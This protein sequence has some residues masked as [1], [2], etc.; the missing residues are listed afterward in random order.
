MEES[1]GTS[2][3]PIPERYRHPRMSGQPPAE[4]EIR[5][6]ARIL[7]QMSEAVFLVDAR[8]RTIVYTKPGSERMFGYGQGEL[9]GK[10]MTTLAL[11][12]VEAPDGI[13]AA[14]NA[15][16]YRKGVWKGELLNLKKNGATFWCS[17]AVSTFTHS[18]YGEVWLAVFQDISGR[19][20]AEQALHESE[21]FL[22]S[23]VENIPDMIFVK[24][25]EELRFIKFNGAGEELLGYRREEL[26]GKNDY[27]FFPPEEAEFF[28]RKDREVL[29]SKQL[30]D[31]AEEFIDTR[32]HGKRVLHTKKIP[33]ADGQGNPLFLLGISEDVTERNRLDRERERYLRFFRLSS[34]AMCIADPFGCFKDVNPALVR[35]TGYA[36]EELIAIPFLDFVH[37]EDREDTTQVIQLLVADRPAVNF[38]NRYLCKDGRV[39]LLSWMAY[40]DQTDGY[41]Y[42]S[43]RDITELR[44]AEE[45]LSRMN[46]ELEGY[47]KART[48]EL[49]QKNRELE[50]LNRS[51]VGRELRMVELKERI[52]KL[53]RQAV[54]MGGQDAQP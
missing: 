29:N 43:A 28:T 15:T 33:I 49:E 2:E 30:V 6:Q 1:K 13:A 31:I 17:A 10:P 20:Q 9:T 41:I 25:A 14:I 26:Y 12:A 48:A 53:E 46:L 44:R 11:P 5:L 23:I 16:L 37:P 7:E 35:L 22:S 19:R 3:I 51:F 4:E 42:A 8:D 38:E 52:K 34:D 40:F 27:D 36:Q 45:A 21:A 54:A 39:L 32:H 47:V 24:D 50:Q 18:R